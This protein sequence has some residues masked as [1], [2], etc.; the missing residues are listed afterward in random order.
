MSYPTHLICRNGHYYY[1]AKVPVDLQQFFPQLF[2]K[3]SLKTTDL[4][5]AKT[6]LLTMEYQV[7]K[8]FTLL[9]T[10]MLD[11]EMVHALVHSLQLQNPE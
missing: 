5:T 11:D 1:K 8:V 4:P 7:N 2:I 9:R 6:A 10:G 3:K